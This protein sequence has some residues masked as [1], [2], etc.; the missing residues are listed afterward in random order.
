[1]KLLDF[2]LPDA[3]VDD[4]LATEKEPAIKE[5]ADSLVLHGLVKAEDVPS[6]LDALMKREELGSTGIG[7]GIAIPHTKH[8]AVHRLVGLVGRSGKGVDF[9]SLDGEPAHLFFLILSPPDEPN[10]HLHALEQVSFLIRDDNYCRFMREA[11]HKEGLN[12]L[13]K[14]ADDRWFS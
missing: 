4:M 8:E 10:D 6:I 12:E 13:L 3:T 5:L 2:I 1:M 14:E 9:K 11:P 7:R